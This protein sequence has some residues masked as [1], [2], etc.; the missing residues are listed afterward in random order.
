MLPRIPYADVLLMSLSGS[1]ILRAYI[2]NQSLIPRQYLRFLEHQGGQL[3]FRPLN[4]E[5]G[6]MMRL[7]SLGI[8]IN[9]TFFAGVQADVGH[10]NDNCFVS[11][12]CEK[13]C[14]VGL[15]NFAGDGMIRALKMY[16]PLNLIVGIVFSH[17]K[18]KNE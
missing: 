4:R 9:R 13:R 16:L 18:M 5:L 3:R 12:P 1:Q 8:P 11:H 7:L 15:F 10:T 6:D 17:K 14:A 2:T